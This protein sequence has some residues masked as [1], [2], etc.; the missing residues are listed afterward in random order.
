MSV[1]YDIQR[2]DVIYNDK[3]N[4]I[5]MSP[6]VPAIYIIPDKALLQTIRNSNFQIPVK[7]TET[8]SPYDNTLAMANCQTAENTAGYRPNFQS[9][10]GYVVLIPDTRWEGYPRK[11]GRVHILLEGE[12]GDSGDSGESS[13]VFRE[14]FIHNKNTYCI[15]S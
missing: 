1:S 6:S 15:I 8:D 11:L 12:K 7:F 14:I 4:S 3:P 10:N 13:N 9:A 5:P 2:W